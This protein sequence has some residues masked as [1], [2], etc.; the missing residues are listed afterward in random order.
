MTPV[1]FGPA[2]KY[3]CWRM[4]SMKAGYG[5]ADR[6]CCGGGAAVRRWTVG[7]VMTRDVVCV[8]ERTEY[9]DIV[10]TLVRHGV[11]AVP[12]INT[13]GRILGVVSEADVLH[14]MEFAGQEPHRHLLE[15]KQR[16]T[17]RA[18]A[19]GETAAELMTEPA[20]TIAPDATIGAAAMLMDEETVKRLPVVDADGGVVGIVSR[21][22]LLRVYLRSDE[23]IRTEIEDQVLL[24]ALWIEPGTITVT[25]RKGVVSLAGTVDRRSTIPIVVRLVST[26]AGVV[27]VENN[28]TYH[29]DDRP[30]QH[31]KTPTAADVLPGTS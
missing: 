1:T 26:V 10:E 11:S 19:G 21:S 9:K 29:Y 3:A 25:A 14:K 5:S 27:E 12:V 18:K 24:R 17:M 28:L 20:V 15:R 16:R 4:V 2:R 31:M 6:E 30:D 7:D 13:D 22:D 8:G 23:E